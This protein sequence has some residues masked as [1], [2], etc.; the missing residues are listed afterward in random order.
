MDSRAAASPGRNP[1]AAVDMGSNS[2]RLEIGQLPH[3]HLGRYRRID[4]LKETVRLGAGLDAA[5]LLN[6]E[7][8]QRGLACL[9]RFAARL[10]GFDPSQVRAKKSAQSP[11][12][13]CAKH[14]TAMPSSCAP[15]RRWVIPSR[16]SPAVKKRA[17]FTPVWPRCSPAKSGAWSWTSAAGRRK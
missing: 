4:Y 16:S 11:R 17:S 6:D 15:R 2:F 12:R 13:P 14:A 9:R 8:A 10:T 5:G 1:M 7:A 3:G